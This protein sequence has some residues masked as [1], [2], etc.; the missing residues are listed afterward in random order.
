MFGAIVIAYNDGEPA[1]VHA[2]NQKQCERYWRLWT[3]RLYAYWVAQ[4]DM[5]KVKAEGFG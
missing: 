4:Y 1:T 3:K 2:M 5:K